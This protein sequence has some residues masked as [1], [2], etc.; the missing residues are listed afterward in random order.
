VTADPRHYKIG[1]WDVDI[2]YYSTVDG[3]GAWRLDQGWTY[4]GKFVQ[5]GVEWLRDWGAVQEH[6]QN[7]E[8]LWQLGVAAAGLGIGPALRSIGNIISDLTALAKPPGPRVLNLGSGQNPMKGAVNVDVRDLPGVD[9]ITTPGQALPTSL[10][11]FDEVV[12]INPR[13][14]PDSNFDILG[15]SRPVLEPG[16]TLTIVGQDGNFILRQ[17][18]RMT[19]EELASRGFRR[20]TPAG[21]TV[22]ADPRFNFGV[23]RTISGYVIDPSSYRQI[24]LQRIS[25]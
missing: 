21:Q 5:T 10:G 14:L 16:K 4:N 22:K 17:I 15:L 11:K 24:T 19:D 7:M 12:V 9:V 13:E 23:A 1:R 6:Y 8:M 18:N 20:L 3:Q 25:R 2:T